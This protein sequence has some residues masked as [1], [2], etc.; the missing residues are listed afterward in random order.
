MKSKLLF[1]GA[2]AVV[3]GVASCKKEAGPT[4]ATGPQGSQGPVGP[5]L[6]GNLKGF[7]SHFDL[8]GSKITTNLLGDSVSIDATT[9]VSV[10]DATGYFAFTGLTTG[11]YNLTVKRAGYGITKIQGVQFTGGG[12]TYRNANI[13][14][15]PTSN[16][17]TLTAMDTVVAGV[18]TVRLRGTIPTS[19]LAQSII[20]FVG[21]PGNST[22]SS[23]TSSE[24]SS[25]VFSV[26]SG[27]TATTSFRK[28]I[29]T[30]DLYDIGYASG[31][32]VYF[33]GYT[34]GGNTNASS[35]SDLTNNKPIYTA[36]GT[37]PLLVNAPVQ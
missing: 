14:K 32:T 4:G 15:I 37:T 21:L 19:T 5:V 27:T 22:V 28:D 25:Y 11:V 9:M 8:S 12:D 23:S 2:V 30:T 6:T 7:I 26:P 17:L 35:Y 16:L 29:P 13:S 3:L 18:N 36:L 1:I 10:T 31:N 20:V 24:S 34:I 33:A